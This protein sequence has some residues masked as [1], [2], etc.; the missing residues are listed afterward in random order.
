MMES[1]LIALIQGWLNTA[2]QI[3]I[4][5]GVGY[6]IYQRI[7]ADRA[8][9]RRAEV[10]VAKVADVV[11]AIAEVKEQTNGMSHR[12]EALAGEAGEG[13]GRALAAAE[14]KKKP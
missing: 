4:A 9:A 11:V 5:A 2:T 6:G 1:A 7:M 10:V 14:A 12:L 8:A 13:R 3:V